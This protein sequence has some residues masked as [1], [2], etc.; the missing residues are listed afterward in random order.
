[1]DM[2]VK[3]H[4]VRLICIVVGVSLSII[5]LHS[6]SILA[7]LH[8]NNDNNNY[9]FA[10]TSDT[11]NSIFLKQNMDFPNIIISDNLGNQDNAPITL[12]HS[13][14]FAEDTLFPQRFESSAASTNDIS[15]NN[16]M[17]L[18]AR[19]TTL[20]V[21][22]IQS[23]NTLVLSLHSLNDKYLLT[24]NLKGSAKLGVNST[25]DDSQFSLTGNIIIN[26]NKSYSVVAT[27]DETKGKQVTLT[28][29]DSKMPENFKATIG[30][31]TPRGPE[32]MP[33]I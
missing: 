5:G 16:G 29:T 1:M 9:V 32:A 24:G 25:A 21:N 7:S 20:T 18:P 30:F 28:M 4:S 11:K 33:G 26:K 8:N 2:N 10:I 6:S 3:Q 17:T 27:L 14:S 22:K 19:P 13:I 15:L 12:F 31:S 23:N